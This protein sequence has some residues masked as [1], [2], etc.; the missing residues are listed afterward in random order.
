[1]WTDALKCYAIKYSLE[2]WPCSIKLKRI[3]CRWLSGL[4]GLAFVLCISVKK[5]SCDRAFFRKKWDWN[6]VGIVTYRCSVMII[7]T[8]HR[9]EANRDALKLLLM[10]LQMVKS[11]RMMMVPSQSWTDFCHRWGLFCDTIVCS[12]S[13]AN[14]SKTFILLLFCFY[15]ALESSK[16]LS[17]SAP[18]AISEELPQQKLITTSISDSSFSSGRKNQR[19]SKDSAMEDENCR[20]LSGFTDSTEQSAPVNFDM[21]NRVRPIPNVFGYYSSIWESFIWNRLFDFFLFSKA[22]LPRGIKNIRPHLENVDNVPLL[23]SLFTDC[24]AEATCEMLQIMQNY[25]EIV[26]CI[27]SS[28][29][30]ANADTFLQ[31]DCSI[32]IEPLYPQVSQKKKNQKKSLILLTLFFRLFLTRF[33]KISQLIRNQIF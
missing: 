33:A 13:L 22:K 11:T 21:S 23:V 3:W 8:Q 19:V 28:A 29:S 20:S 1:M 26:V 27:G 14:F 17:T 31:A 10:Q 7:A 9:Q 30:C 2:W 16:T 4:N 12:F 25:G 32:A 15:S 24:S 5:M 6:R 18:G